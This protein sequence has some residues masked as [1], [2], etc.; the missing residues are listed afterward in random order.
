M[1]AAFSALILILISALFSGLTLG[2]MGLSAPSLHRKAQ[3]GDER[4]KKIYSVRKD[5]NLLL[6][7]LLLGNV[8]VNTAIALV[9]NSVASG[10][11]AG[12]ASTLLIVVFGEIFP[13]AICARYALTVG[14]NTVGFVKVVRA[15]LYPITK[16]LAWV[17]DRMLG[18]ELATIW[19]KRELSMIIAQHEDD[20]RSPIDAE[21][22]R[23]LLGALRFS[24]QK[25]R[26]AMTPA[27][28]VFMLE[29]QTPLT[30]PMLK[31]I[32][33]EGCTRIPVYSGDPDNM[34]GMLFVKDLIGYEGQQLS[35]VVRGGSFL[36]INEN[37]HLDHLF[38]AF[39]T[40]SPRTHLA[41]VRNGAGHF[42]GI[43]TLEDV[44]EEIIAQEIDD[45]SDVPH[46][47]AMIA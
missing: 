28:R 35:D 32:A 15:V 34:I 21:E 25:I 9:M 19:S 33:G 17:L 18:E 5:G 30:L 13:Q 37:E 2:L 44:L 26:A 16:P 23:I 3:L 1:V 41:L 24:E 8:G 20:D 22:E 12:V 14:A 11:V 47:R 42:V 31:R 43:I 7:T 38:T 45:E 29:L 10:V 40:S 27:D 36:E 39:L 46:V 6:C 4:A